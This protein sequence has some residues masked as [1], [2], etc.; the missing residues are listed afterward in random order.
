MGQKS[1]FLTFL[2][3]INL[4]LLYHDSKRK[5]IAESFIEIWI[6]YSSHILLILHLNQIS[7]YADS[8]LAFYFIFTLL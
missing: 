2:S 7:I 8:L 3:Y 4:L 6:F 5:D 1:F